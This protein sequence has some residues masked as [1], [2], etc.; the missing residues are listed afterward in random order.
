MPAEIQMVYT[1]IQTGRIARITDYF[2]MIT[3]ADLEE[4]TWQNVQYKFIP[5]EV[6]Q[7]VNNWEVNMMGI[8]KKA[9]GEVS[10]ETKNRLDALNLRASCLEGISRLV[11]IMRFRRTK[12]VYGWPQL[13]PMYIAEIKTYRETNIA[14]PL[15]SSLVTD[16]NELPISIAEFELA[17]ADYENFL[18]STEVMRN[19]WVRQIK[20]AE[21]PEV[22]LALIKRALGI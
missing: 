11:N 8:F 15:L 7:N 20:Q 12:H 18:Q 6:Y 16:I 10:D 1:D 21:N 13:V 9:P 14:G 3:P 5:T 22:T 17:N 2:P 19:K 4:L